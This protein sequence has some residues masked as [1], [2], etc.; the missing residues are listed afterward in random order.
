MHSVLPLKL[1]VTTWEGEADAKEG[2]GRGGRAAA[3]VAPYISAAAAVLHGGSSIPPWPTAGA[4]LT[5]VAHGGRLPR[6]P[7]P[8]ADR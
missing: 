2:G 7:L 4:V 6:A 8:A 1:G 3:I 5:A